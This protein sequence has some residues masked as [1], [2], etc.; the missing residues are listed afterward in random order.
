MS[1]R[2]HHRTRRGPVPVL[3]AAALVASP[4]FVVACGD[5]AS[6]TTSASSAPASQAVAVAG[7]WART[8]PMETTR[9]AAYMQ[10]TA[11]VDDRLVGASVDPSVAA[12]VEV[13][14]TV[15]EDGG[16]AMQEV[17]AIDL[18][19]GE[20]VA[21]EPGGY[22]IMLMDLVAPLAVDSTITITLEF[23]QSGEQNVTVVVRD[24]AP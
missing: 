5:D 12:A 7:A 4:V 14:E 15:M 2:R 18:P 20:T 9:G 24:D 17:P 23:E 22:H 10:L 6:S 11:P 8:S 19:A 16:M 13:H 21:L 1:R 3:I